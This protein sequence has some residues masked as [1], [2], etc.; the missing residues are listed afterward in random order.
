VFCM[1]S[2]LDKNWLHFANVAE[3][4]ILDCGCGT[5]LWRE[6]LESK[7]EVIGVDVNRKYLEKSLYTNV[8]LCS[9]THFRSKT[10]FLTLCGHVL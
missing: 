10:E 2:A 4:S 3:G 1:S 6:V 8:V 7:G 9:V 5:G